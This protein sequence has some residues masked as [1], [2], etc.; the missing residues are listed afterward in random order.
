M[1]C[2]HHHNL[3]RSPLSHLLGRCGRTYQTARLSHI[4]RHGPPGSPT[5]HRPHWLGSLFR[6][7]PL[8]FGTQSPPRFVFS[9]L[10]VVLI[11]H[12]VWEHLISVAECS[13]PSMVP[14]LPVD[15]NFLLYSKLHRRG[16]GCKVG[17]LVSSIHP[18]DSSVYVL[19]RIIGM[20]G[21]FICV[22]PG[23][24]RRRMIQVLSGPFSWK[25]GHAR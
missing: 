2:S 19:K 16:R 13:G 8:L 4:L 20:P 5:M 17:D 9:T 1:Q 15:G 25:W 7:R 14:T 3:R 23:G 21:D 18:Q 22:D 12:L 11:T 24:G 6:P 10:K